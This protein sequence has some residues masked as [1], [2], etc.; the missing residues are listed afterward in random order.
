MSNSI[1]ISRQHK[2]KEGLYFHWAHAVNGSQ[3]EVIEHGGYKFVATERNYY[4][5]KSSNRKIRYHTMSTENASYEW[6]KD[7]YVEI[8]KGVY[9]YVFIASEDNMSEKLD[10]CVARGNALLLQHPSL[11]ED[12]KSRLQFIDNKKPPTLADLIHNAEA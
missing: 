4:F 1:V 11:N 6:L 7:V 5:A 9:T 2:L 10:A 12:I 3:F 8:D